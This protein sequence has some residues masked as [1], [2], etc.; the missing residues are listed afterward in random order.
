MTLRPALMLG[1][2]LGALSLRRA[3]A[4]PG[5]Q[6]A[7]RPRIAGTVS[8]DRA[9]P[10]VETI[11][12]NSPSAIIRWVPNVGGNPIIFLPAGRTATFVNGVSNSQFRRAQPDPGER[13]DPL[14]RHGAQPPAGSGAGTSA[15]G[16]TV[17]FESPGGIIVG[18]NGDVRRR[19][20]HPHHP[21]RR[22]RRR[23]Q[24]HRRRAAP[25][26][27]AGGAK[28]QGGDR[29]EPG[30]QILA[31]TQ[32]SYVALHRAGRPAGR[33]GPGQRLGRLCRRPRRSSSGPMPACSTSSSPPAAR[34]AIPLDPHRRD[35]RPGQHRRR[36]RPPHLHGGGAQE[37][38]DHRDPPG[39]CRLR[40]GGRRRRREW[41]DRSF[42][43]LQRRRRRARP[44]RR[45][46]RRAGARPAGELRDPRRHDHL[47]PVR[48]CGHQHAGER[49]GD[50]QPRLRSRTSACSAASRRRCPPART[51]L[52]PSAATRSSPTAHFRTINLNPIDLAGGTAL[53]FADGGGS[54]DI[55]GN[56]IVDSSAQGVVNVVTSTAGH[57]TGGTAGLFANTGGSVRVRGDT[58]RA[59][60]RRRRR[61][62]SLAQSRR[63]RPGR[64]RARRRPQR[65]PG[66]ARRHAWRWTRAAPAAARTARPIPAPPAPAATP[67]SP[68]LGGGTVN[69]AGA[70][71]L[72][73]NGTG[74]EVTGGAIPGGTGRGGTVSLAA[75]GTVTFAGD[76]VLN[77]NGFGGAGPTGGTAQGGTIL[78]AATP[79]LGAPGGSA[80]TAGNVTGTASATG[81]AAAGNT[82][83]EWH[84]SAGAGSLI[85][86]ANLTLTAAA[87]GAAGGAALLEPGGAARADQRHPDRDP[88]D[89]GRHQG[90]RRRGG[91]DH[92]RVARHRRGRRRDRHPHQSRRQF[93]DRRHRP[94]YRRHQRHRRRRQRDP[95]EQPDRRRRRRRDDGRRRDGRARDRHHLGQRGCACGRQRRQRDHRAR[96]HKGDRQR[97]GR[98]HDPRPQHPRR[99]ERPHCGRDRDRGRRG[100]GPDRAARRRQCGDRGPG[101]RPLDPGHGRRHQRRA[102]PA[103]S[104]MRRPS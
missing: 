100:D 48:L 93:H 78:L 13:A 77:A 71:A 31:N 60:D 87:N 41:R 79:V 29:T 89:A 81:A 18:T 74:G 22:H 2:A 86:L 94:R 34:I 16:G 1:C 37:P 57:G 52:S 85:D 99:L 92:R 91:P 65:R 56:A 23:R 76:P 80:L 104:A 47:R 83:G 44:L 3:G 12:L 64:R 17:I 36:R 84:V 59:R 69:V 30:A 38:G 61:A 90:D 32:G 55:F 40:S 102:R 72:T 51:R 45:L 26:H 35:R 9:T 14:R 4:G 25:I 33:H 20:P 49:L 70:T 54:V 24:L 39:Q 73:A 28:A 103:R 15:P 98:R 10:G 67:M 88:G 101:P 50:R 19:Q 75:N 21:H 58:Q 27:F 6:R 11:T 66:P 63:Q 5:V 53:I 96:R 68:R 97:L 42:R 7:I 82:P 43:R 46:H 95:R 62:R 8:Y